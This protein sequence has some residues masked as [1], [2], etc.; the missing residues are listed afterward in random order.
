M[1]LKSVKILGGNFRSLTENKLYEFNVSERTD[2]L[3]TKCFAGLN[4]SGKSNMLELLAE[5]FYFLEYQHLKQGDEDQKRGIGFGF[6]IEYLMPMADYNRNYV[7]GKPV[8]GEW[9]WV[10]I[11]K[12]LDQEDPLEYSV[13]P[14]KQDNISFVRVDSEEGRQKLLPQKIIAYTSG[15]NELLSNPFYKLKYHY[16]REAEKSTE[17]C[18][19]SDRMFFIDATNNFNLF[20]ALMLLGEERKT[21]IIKKMCRIDGIHSFR[22]TINTHKDNQELSFTNYITTTIEKL[23]ACATSWSLERVSGYPKASKRKQYV[24][25]YLVSDATKAAFAYYFDGSAMTLFK[26]LYQLDMQNI[27]LQKDKVHNLVH[28]ANKDLNISDEIPDL[29][30]DELIFR[31]EKILLNKRNKAA[32][33]EKIKYKNLSDGEHQLNEVIGS[34]AILEDNGCLLLYDEPDTHFNPKWRGGIIRLFNEMAALEYDEKTNEITRVRN[35]EVIIT[36]HSPFAISDSYREDVY[37]FE[38]REVKKNKY[39]VFIENPVEHF[40]TYGASVGSILENIF[41]RDKTIADL[42]FSDLETLKK[43]TRNLQQLNAAKE[44]LGDFGESIEKFDAISY[45]FEK[46][47]EI[48]LRAKRRSKIDQV[49]KRKKKGPN[50]KKK[51]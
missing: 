5:I 35:Q 26:A 32:E 40:K 28:T 30:A 47:D 10:R 41:G 42:A 46:E 49:T 7:W 23:K 1:K 18:E 43:Q 24:L 9:M 15:Q 38:N 31:V 3:S 27:R 33:T 45:L 36:T 17:E 37:C 2:R 48:I 13:Q 19:M 6:E 20:L 44:E 16:F 8:K 29:N 34:M 14:W 22:I 51:R 50:G 21:N 4:G 11:V 12:P 25:D 39:E